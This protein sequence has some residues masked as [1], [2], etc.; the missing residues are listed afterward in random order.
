MNSGLLDQGINLMLVGMATVFVFLTLL[1]FAITLS[2]RVLQLLGGSDENQSDVTSNDGDNSDFR[3][4]A[5]AVAL[6]HHRT[7]AKKTI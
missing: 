4:A 7:R 3:T 2:A 1:V 5:I 6:H